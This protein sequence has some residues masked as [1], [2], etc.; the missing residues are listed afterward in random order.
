MTGGGQLHEQRHRATPGGKAVVDDDD[1]AAAGV[2]AEA[3]QQTAFGIVDGDD[4]NAVAALD[5]GLGVGAAAFDVHVAR[6][7]GEAAELVVVDDG[8]VAFADDGAITLADE[9]AIAFARILDAPGV[10]G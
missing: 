1:L 8:A 9:G 7:N 4:A 6:A 5:D 10:P 2:A 3:P